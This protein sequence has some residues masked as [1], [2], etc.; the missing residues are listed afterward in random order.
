MVV[1]KG[2]IQPS[3]SVSEAYRRSAQALNVIGGTVKTQDQATAK[4]EG[5]I[6]MS[7]VSWGE[8]I[9]IDVAAVGD[10]AIVRITSSSRWPTTLFDWGKNARNVRRFL[11]WLGR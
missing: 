10:G 9:L 8:N 7:M 11:E 6:S 1:K 2:E 4:I 3:A 5:T